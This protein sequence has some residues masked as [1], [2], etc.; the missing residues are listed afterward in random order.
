[1]RTVSVLLLFGAAA[2]LAPDLATKENLVI[3]VL[4]LLTAVG[5]VRVLAHE[6]G[7]AAKDVWPAAIQIIEGYYVFRLRLLQLQTEFRQARLENA[8]P[9]TVSPAASGSPSASSN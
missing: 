1:L 7:A 8:R 3:V 5:L 6:S 2:V 9:A 4:G